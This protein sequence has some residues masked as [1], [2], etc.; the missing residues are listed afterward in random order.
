MGISTNLEIA[1][2]YNSGLAKVA[3]RYS[4]DTFVVKFAAFAKLQ[5]VMPNANQVERFYKSKLSE[6]DIGQNLWPSGLK[7]RI[8]NLVSALFCACNPLMALNGI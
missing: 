4:A 5:N 6:R 2:T 3:V 8:Q 7:N 1:T